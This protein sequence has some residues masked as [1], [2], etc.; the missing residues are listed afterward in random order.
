MRAW[1]RE[2]D[3][4]A[5]THNDSGVGPRRTASAIAAHLW[6]GMREWGGGE[7]TSHPGRGSWIRKA[8]GGGGGVR[9]AH[10]PTQPQGTATMSSR[11]RQRPPP[12]RVKN[13]TACRTGQKH[14]RLE[15]PAEAASAGAAPTRVGKA[16]APP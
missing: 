7:R 3:P 16:A 14:G 13:T 1:R 6:Q 5:P 10:K 8:G 4:V 9:R 12:R 11:Q 2:A 15:S